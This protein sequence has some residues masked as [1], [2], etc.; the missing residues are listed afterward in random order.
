[1][2]VP[3]QHC[4]TNADTEQIRYAYGCTRPTIVMLYCHAVVQGGHATHQAC[5]LHTIA[6]TAAPCV[7]RLAR[8]PPARTASPCATRLHACCS[9]VA[10]NDTHTLHLLAGDQMGIG[11]RPWAWERARRSGARRGHNVGHRHLRPTRAMRAANE[12]WKQGKRHTRVVIAR[13]C[14]DMARA[15][16]A[17]ASKLVM[18]ESYEPLPPVGALCAFCWVGAGTDSVA[19]AF[20]D[21]P[22]AEPHASTGFSRVERSSLIRSSSSI[23]SSS[24]ARGST[25]KLVS[26]CSSCVRVWAVGVSG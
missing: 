22:S 26:C 7:A 18:V 19:T 23:A 10:S 11:R 17:S 3:R 4:R 14:R 12:T 25:G 20:E 16:R 2:Y 1:M 8:R 21:E 5:H 6:T 13:A 24:S 9:T 15:A